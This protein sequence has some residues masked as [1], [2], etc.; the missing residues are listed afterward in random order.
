MKRRYHLSVTT[1]GPLYPPSEVMDGDGNFIVIGAVNGTDEAGSVT[2][3]WGGAIVS[4]SSPLP[5]FGERAPYDILET[6]DPEN[7][8]RHLSRRI[9]HTLP[10]PLPCNNYGMVFAPAQRPDADLDVRKSFP[11]HLTPIPDAEWVHGRQM[12]SPVTLGDWIKAKGEL[13]VSLENDSREARFSFVFSGLVPKSVYTIMTLREDDLKPGVRT[14]PGP[15]GIPNVFVT[16]DLGAAAFEAVLPDPFPPGSRPGNRVIN[17]VVLFMSYQ[18]SH[19]GAIGIYGLGGDIHAQLKLPGK[20]FEEFETKPF[21]EES[22]TA[23]P[24]YLAR[25][26]PEATNRNV[27]AFFDV[28]ETLIRTKSMF[29]FYRFFCGLRGTTR[30]LEKFEADFADMLAQGLPREDLNRIYYSYLAG[31]SPVELERAGQL[32]WLE[33]SKRPGFF[34]Q[35]SCDLLRDLQATG[36]TAVFVSGSF[37]EILAPIGREFGVTNFLCAPMRVGQNGLYDGSLGAPQTIGTGKA[38]AITLFLQEKAAN[39]TVCWAVGDDLSDLPMLELVGNPVAVGD[40]TPLAIRA[41]ER[42]WVVLPGGP[43]PSVRRHQ[44]DE[45]FKEGADGHFGIR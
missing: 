35:E 18:M 28:D 34:L 32:W 45:R 27:F 14:R 42:G 24:T 10:L 44:G 21:P 33:V 25:T 20:A 31:V 38:E 29:D 15:L 4:P 39:P 6:F 12:R 9:L 43:L 17:V 7:L 11:F 41:S 2:T 16:D 23:A 26:E 19:G 3:K 13:T 37:K 8:P 5:N 22:E 30:E 1:Q 36:V 40:Q